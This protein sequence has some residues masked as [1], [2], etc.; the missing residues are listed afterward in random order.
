MSIYG[1]RRGVTMGGENAASGEERYPRSVLICRVEGG[2]GRPTMPR[3]GEARGLC[4]V[5]PGAAS[6]PPIEGVVK[7]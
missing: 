3:K 7:D 2:Y 6:P 1:A 5:V 4:R